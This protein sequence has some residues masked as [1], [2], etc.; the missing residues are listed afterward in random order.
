[1]EYLR[2][3]TIEEAL[4]LLAEGIPLG[5]GTQLVSDRFDLTKVIDLQ[6]LGL[7]QMREQ[8]GL[9]SI[10]A[11][12]RLQSLLTGD[13]TLPQAL[14]AACRFEAAWNIRNQATLGGLLIGADGRKEPFIL[15]E[16]S[17]KRPL[18]LA[19]DYVARAPMDTPIVSAAAAMHDAG[20]KKGITVSIGGYGEG[21]LFWTVDYNEDRREALLSEVAEKAKGYFQ[22]AGDA[23]ASAEYRAEVAGI[24]VVRVVSEV[25]KAC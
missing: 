6:S 20:E 12:T 19:Y 4:E 22:E 5:G 10:G 23:F 16:M 2:P 24:L 17:F 21:P 11:M 9:I 7:D 13:V 15:L 14:R 1:M 18:C 25:M 3:K 8:D